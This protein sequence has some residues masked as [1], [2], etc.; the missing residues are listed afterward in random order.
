MTLPCEPT[1]AGPAPCTTQRKWLF[2]A[3]DHREVCMA[4]SAAGLAAAFGA[5]IGG[6]LFS[7]EEAS[8]HWSRKTIWVSGAGWQRGG[9]VQCRRVPPNH[10]GDGMWGSSGDGCGSVPAASVPLSA[11]SWHLQPPLARPDA[12]LLWLR[13]VSAPLWVSPPLPA[14]PCPAP[15]RCFLCAIAA[16]FTLSQ[17]HPRAA[18]GMLQLRGLYSLTNIQWLFQM[19]FIILASAGGGL[20]GAVFNLLRIRLR[21]ARSRQQGAAAVLWGS[22]AVALL[23][24]LCMALLPKYFG[25]CLEVPQEWGTDNVVRQQWWVPLPALAWLGC[26]PPAA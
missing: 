14:P 15:Q 2:N 12:G 21:K 17:L 20:L 4:G 3:V 5:P 19:G 7:L 22:A 6:V 23:T 1:E 8:T 24:V 18:S 26:G 9:L 13:P 11:A 25:R 10:S 16:T